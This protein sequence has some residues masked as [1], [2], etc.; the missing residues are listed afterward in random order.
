M[1]ANLLADKVAVVTGGASGNGR[2]IAL[3]FAREGAKAVVVVDLRADPREGGRS[4]H[5]LI[6]AETSTK[7]VFVNC[8]VTK[9]AE[10]E[11]AVA[12]A[13]AFGGVDVMVNNAGIAMAPGSSGDLLTATEAQFDLMIGVNVKGV[14]FGCQ[15]AAKRMLPKGGGSII[16]MSSVSGIQGDGG[17][18]IY[19]T[20]KGAV[21]L[22]TYGL[23][24]A[25]GP[26]GIRV[27]AIHPGVIATAM[28]T[29]DA[30]IVGGPME[31][32]MLGMIPMGRFGQPKEIGD[33]AVYLA[34]DMASYVNG[35]SLIVDGGWKRV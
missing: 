14:Y 6:E 33:A 5:E 25:L 22:M 24:A 27:N 26:K 18:A 19:N 35:A 20:T 4:T 23:A 2:A 12:A 1:P 32:M 9:P 16:I 15:A 3:A 30:P 11:A 8:N 34:S 17:D 13:D 7:S 21:R 31:A 29:I 28:T 10:V